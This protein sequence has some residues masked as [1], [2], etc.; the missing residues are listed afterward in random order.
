[1]A[2]KVDRDLISAV[3]SVF[4]VLQNSLL[5]SCVEVDVPGDI[6]QG[7]RRPDSPMKNTGD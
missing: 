7:C 5:K 4:L 2:T 6:S 1:M 3:H